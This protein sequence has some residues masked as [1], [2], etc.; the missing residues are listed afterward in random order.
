VGARKRGLYK[1]F[2]TKLFLSTL[3]VVMVYSI[4]KILLVAVFTFRKLTSMLGSVRCLA[5]LVT[6]AFCHWIMS[7]G[8]LIIT[9]SRLIHHYLVQDQLYAGL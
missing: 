1:N 7:R 2:V 4:F 5:I 8:Y 6:S 9:L 3:L